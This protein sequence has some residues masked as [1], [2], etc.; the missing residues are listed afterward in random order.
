MNR[1]LDVEM[2]FHMGRKVWNIFPSISA[3]LSFLDKNLFKNRKIK[4]M[5]AR[6]RYLLFYDREFGSR[7]GD[8]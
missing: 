2:V 3:H 5:S 1:D 7:K 8:Q 6:V 4:I